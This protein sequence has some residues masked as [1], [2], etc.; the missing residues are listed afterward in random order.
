MIN[1]SKLL[2]SIPSLTPPPAQ[3]A[4]LGSTAAASTSQTLTAPDPAPPKASAPAKSKRPPILVGVESV[5]VWLRGQVKELLDVKLSEKTKELYERNGSRLD[6]QR[7]EG[8]A[9]SLKNYE[10]TAST[11]YAYRAALRWHAAKRGRDAMNEYDRAKKAKDES[12]AAAAWQRILYAAADLKTYTKDTAPG[13]P[14]PGHV[15]LGLADAK[16]E[17]AP[18]KAKR[19]GR[20]AISTRETSKLKAANAIAKKYPDWR[21]RLWLRLVEIESPWLDHTAVAGLTGARPDELR[22]A[23]F[24]REGDTLKIGIEGAKVTEKNGQP[25]RMFT[26]KN[27]GTHEFAHLFAKAGASW[28]TVDLPGGVTDYPDAFSAALARAGKQVFPKSARMSGYVYRHAMASD[29]KADGFTRE[30]IAAALGHAA[31]KT[32]DAYGRAIGGSAGKRNLSVSCAREIRATHD[33]RY[34]NPAPQVAPASMTVTT[35]NFGSFGL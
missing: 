25:W 30:S 5:N 7:V 29:L 18:A 11:F 23:K 19:E 6:G 27:D 3:S 12:T 21:E 10:G 31:T 28:K 24:Q 32:Q 13:I 26:L 17:G 14:A 2:K 8:E 15:A 35:P 34:T 4:A 16:P 9:V 1:R 20:A 33:T 22:K